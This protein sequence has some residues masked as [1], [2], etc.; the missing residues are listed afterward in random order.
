MSAPESLA[1]ACCVVGGG[2]AGMMAGF[3]LA[4]AGIEVVVLEKHAD[5]FRDFRGDTIHPSTLELMHELGFLEEFL[6]V[7]HQQLAQVQVNVAGAGFV[8]ADFSHLPTHCKFIAFMPQWDFLSFLVEQAKKYPSFRLRMGA[9]A[10]DLIRTGDRVTGVTFR[11]AQGEGEV[12]AGLVLAAD[13]RGSILRERAGLAVMDF[14]VPIDVLWLRL[15]KGPAAPSQTL[16]YID[17]RRFMV[18]LDREDYYQCGYIIRKGTF[19][20]IRQGGLPAFRADLVQ[21]APFLREAVEEVADWNEVKLLTVKID[22]LTRWHVPGL[23]C[24]GDSA[25]AMSPAGGVGINLAIQDAVAATNLLAPAFGRGEIG[26][27]L[28]RRV[29]RRREFPARVIQALQVFVHHRM[30]PAGPRPLSPPRPAGS[31]PWPAKLLRLF[32]FLR[33]IP[34]RLIGLGVRPEHIRSQPAAGT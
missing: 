25:H 12:R 7:R 1:T 18:L 31:V 32:P 6:Q 17:D 8:V 20:A 5:F 34:G 14:N 3:L 4:R 24:I 19:D 10:T 26:E 11:T 2:P 9:E 21:L 22:R 28:L 13:G 33:R 29:Q 16:G 30:F 23:L 27:N 15:A